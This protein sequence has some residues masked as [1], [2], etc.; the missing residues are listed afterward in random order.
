MSDHKVRP[1]IR[2]THTIVEM[3]V[4]QQAYDEIRAKLEEAGYDHVFMEDGVIDM[5]GIGITR[6][7]P[8]QLKTTVYG[9][10]GGNGAR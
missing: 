9:A 1:P 7:E 2:Q 10:G 4:S 6:G 3:D 8:L 5:T